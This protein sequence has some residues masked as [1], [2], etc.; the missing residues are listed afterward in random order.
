V[1]PE[2]KYVAISIKHTKAGWKF[3]KPCVLWGSER[4]SADDEKRRFGG[5]TEYLERAERYAK[6]DFFTLGGYEPEFEIINPTPVKMSTDL[7]RKNRRWDT[8]LVEYED[9]DIYCKAASLPTQMNTGQ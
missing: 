2:R 1:N 5:Y 4:P 9:Y 3:G 8:V 6:D 7:C